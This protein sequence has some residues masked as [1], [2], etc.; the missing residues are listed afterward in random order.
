M[1]S[2]TALC[3]AILLWWAILK[4]LQERRN[5]YNFTFQTLPMKLGLMLVIYHWTKTIMFCFCYWKQ[6]Y[7]FLNILVLLSSLVCFKRVMLQFLDKIKGP[8]LLANTETTISVSKFIFL[9][10]LNICNIWLRLTGGLVYSFSIQIR[11][12]FKTFL[13]VHVDNIPLK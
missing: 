11:S 7:F 8:E 13:I 6:I 10:T 3:S 9:D 2:V 4:H 5:Y 12:I 1:I